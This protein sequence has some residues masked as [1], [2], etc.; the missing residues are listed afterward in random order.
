M[1][2]MSA[3]YKDETE[4]VRL[5]KVQLERVRKIAEKNKRTLRAEL[6]VVIDKGLRSPH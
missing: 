6:E 4:S 2:K 1:T 3:K 5:S